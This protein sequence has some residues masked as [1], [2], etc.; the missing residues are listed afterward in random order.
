M[1][2]CNDQ[3]DVDD[4]LSGNNNFD[5]VQR[6]FLPIND[7]L[8]SSQWTKPGGGR[9]WS[10]LQ[11]L[12]QKHQ[13]AEVTNRNSDDATS[14]QMWH[15][16]SIQGHNIEAART[17]ASKFQQILNHSAAKQTLPLCP[18]VSHVTV[19]D[20]KT[21]QQSNGYD[22]GVHVLV[23]AEILSEIPTTDVTR[24]TCEQLLRSRVTPQ[25]CP[26]MRLR[27][28]REVRNLHHALG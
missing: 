5:C 4:F 26:E 15:F 14:Y 9:H 20:C 24:E 2:Q 13:T 1:N 6:M 22:C 18:S 17:V 21:P 27:I 16:D 25:T 7:L 3:E 11:I 23:A 19:I 28:G 8:G 12:I 10:L